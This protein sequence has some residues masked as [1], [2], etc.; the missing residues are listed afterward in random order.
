MARATE[1]RRSGVRM[2]AGV[3]AGSIPR[4]TA[5]ALAAL[6]AAASASFAPAVHASEL[7]GLIEAGD[8]EAAIALIESGV[9]VDEAQGDGTTPLHWAA[10]RI[11]AGLTA[12]LLEAG[13]DPS[14]VNAY[15]ASPLGE[16]VKVAAED[17]VRL[18]LEAGAD[19]EAANADGQTA[20]MLATRSGSTEIVRL[21][22]EHGA[23]VNAKESWRGQTALIW[24]ADARFPEIVGLL[25]EHG[26]EVD[27][28]AESIDW[29]S[30]ITSEP[31]AQ[32]RPVGGLTPLLYAARAGCTDC[33]RAILAAGADIDR[34]TPEG[35]TPLMLALDNEALDTALLLLDAGADPHL[36]DWY[37]RT[38][39]YIAADKSTVG[40]RGGG[41]D[42]GGARGPG[43]TGPG[44][45]GP[46]V[47]G[48]DVTGLDV[49][50]RLLDAGVDPNP[51]LNMHR[52]SRGG[53]I[54]RFTDDLLTTGCTPLLR[55]AI[56]QDLEAIELML[57]RGALVDLPNVMGVTPLMAA[58]GM[59][60]GRGG[61]FSADFGTERL[62]IEIIGVLLEAGA[63]ID[64]RVV[65]SYDRTARIA[66]DSSMT[67]REGHTALF[68]ATARGWSE[69][70]EFL[71]GRGAAVDIVD[72]HGMTP[73]DVAM[74]RIG[75]RGN[76]VS[77]ELAEQLQALID[78]GR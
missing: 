16:A 38:A 22:L 14:V 30:Q 34:P 26:A 67:A 61:V 25:I 4:A 76:V 44:V 36:W 18:L 31:R 59:G 23:D 53:N 74:G 48:P 28:R 40:R 56:A 24:A 47:T 9:D 17:I 27:F 62:A 11:D 75:G 3:G 35:M 33:V 69:V 39:L 49:I 54:G 45:T 37:G 64:S 73:V 55:L 57:E 70:V 13:A 51:Q 6:A 77:E 32:Y 78:A 71:I 50:R 66:R 58:A 8:R 21:L 15:G 29:P 46:D 7:A 68:A 65:D 42:G 19:A 63:D 20:L 12:R 43:V 72:A 1:L 5:G 52:P 41:R 60:G 10:Y 2:A